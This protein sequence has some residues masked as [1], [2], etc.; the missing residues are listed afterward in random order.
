MYHIIII[1]ITSTTELLKI[2]VLRVYK[3][4][5]VIYK[6]HSTNASGCIET[7]AEYFVYKFS[8]AFSLPCIL[9]A[10]PF[11]SAPITSAPVSFLEI[12]FISSFSPSLFPPIHMVYN[13]LLFF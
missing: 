13:F 11:H 4:K 5:K 12:I 8:V 6:A 9:N 2:Y 7:A 1:K 10:Y 3:K